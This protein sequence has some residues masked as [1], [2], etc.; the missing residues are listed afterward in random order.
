MHTDIIFLWGTGQCKRM[1]LEVTDLRA[2]DEDVLSCSRGD[3]FL[4]DLNF[5]D[6]GRMEDNFGNVGNVSGWASAFAHLD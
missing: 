5:E 3:V 1:V 6:F 2:A 4:L